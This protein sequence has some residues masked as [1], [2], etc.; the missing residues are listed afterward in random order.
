MLAPELQAEETTVLSF[1][2]TTVN[3]NFP[4]KYIQLLTF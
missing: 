4:K 1:N 2:V 3:C